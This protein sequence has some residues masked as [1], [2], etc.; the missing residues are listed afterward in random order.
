MRHEAEGEAL[1]PETTRAFLRVHAE[2]EARAQAPPPDAPTVADL[3]ESLGMPLEEAEAILREARAR[4]AAVAPKAKRRVNP[5]ALLGGVAV[6]IV[7]LG[8]SLVL[9]AA[10]A[11]P[12]TIQ[13]PEVASPV[14]AT[15]LDTT[16]LANGFEISVA[17]GNMETTEP[18][19]TPPFGY[20]TSYR[21]LSPETAQMV[22]EEVAERVVKLVGDPETV[23]HLQN[24]GSLKVVLKVA[25]GKPTTLRVPIPAYSLPFEGNPG[26][27][28][29]LKASLVRTMEAGWPAIV[30]ATPQ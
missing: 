25:G 26:A 4:V 10:P 24:A 7:L 6:G 30:D 13:L 27:R 1:N 3:A 11:D 5:V 17:G 21:A 20:E 9:T 2:R 8:S 28:E 14:Y 16:P 22:R 29:A 18:G 19:T 15:K 12:S 23:G